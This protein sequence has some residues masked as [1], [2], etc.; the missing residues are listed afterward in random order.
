MTF[1]STFGWKRDVIVNTRVCYFLVKL[2]LH[3]IIQHVAELVLAICHGLEL[4]KCLQ[5]SAMTLHL[6]TTVY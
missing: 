4:K 5:E 1:Y 2:F 3:S 6:W